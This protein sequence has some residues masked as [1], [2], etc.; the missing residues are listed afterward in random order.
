MTLVERIARALCERE[1][2]DPEAVTR[3]GDE[4]LPGMTHPTPDLTWKAWESYISEAREIV[5]KM[6][7][8]TDRM[9][10]AG[11]EHRDAA[12]VWSAMID[13]ALVEGPMPPGE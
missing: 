3:L 5:R 7:V 11:G 13:A 10:H 12:A 8:P 1:C 2:L 6:R 9:A 4:L